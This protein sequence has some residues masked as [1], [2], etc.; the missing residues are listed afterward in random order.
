MCDRAALHARVE[1][2]VQGVGFRYFTLERA[3]SHG[4]LGYV[5]NLPDGCVEVRAE[6]TRQDLEALLADL[7]RGPGVSRVSD[8]IATFLEAGIE[9]FREFSVR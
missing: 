6:G 7:R 8:V 5:R 2:R 4:L 1:G 3:I 9:G